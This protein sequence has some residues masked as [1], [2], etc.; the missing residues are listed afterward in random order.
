MPARPQPGF[1]AI[2]ADMANATVDATLARIEAAM[3]E[4]ARN[5]ETLKTRVNNIEST[6]PSYN[7]RLSQ[8][9]KAL[10]PYD[11]YAQECQS[12]IDKLKSLRA[13]LEADRSEDTKRNKALNAKF[14]A[15]DRKFQAVDR[16]FDGLPA[17]RDDQNDINNSVKSLLL[18]VQ[19]LENQ[20]SLHSSAATLESAS[21]RDLAKALLDRLTLGD[22]LASDTAIRLSLLLGKSPPLSAA[23]DRLQFTPPT[24]DLESASRTEG[25]SSPKREPPSSRKRVWNHAE[26]MDSSISSSAEGL[27]SAAKRRRSHPAKSVPKLDMRSS[28]AATIQGAVDPAKENV[29]DEAGEEAEEEE[30]DEDEEEGSATPPIR[31]SGREPKPSKKHGEF[32]TWKQVKDRRKMV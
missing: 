5:Y 12:A 18:R 32:L 29:E 20:A 24:T 30:E 23:T 1:E 26:S 21:A 27:A 10:R 19:Q 28:A 3:E 8:V 11:E 6:T 16:S 7:N 2:M 22:A 14:E 9:E 4:M 15:I 25:D 13:H 17:I 31:R